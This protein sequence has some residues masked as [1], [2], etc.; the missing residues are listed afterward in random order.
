MRRHPVLAVLSGLYLLLV[1]LWPP[2]AAPIVLVA[3]G[4][5][6]VLAQPPVLFAV[7][8]AAVAV[9]YL[10]RPAHTPARRR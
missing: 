8:L 6:T 5:F 4:A 1:G 10:R 3:T 2:A 9:H 7:L